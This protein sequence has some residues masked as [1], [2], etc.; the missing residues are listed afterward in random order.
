MSV[1]EVISYDSSRGGVSVITEKGEVTTSYLLIQHAELAD[2]GKAICRKNIHIATAHLDGCTPSSSSESA[3]GSRPRLPTTRHQSRPRCSQAER[4]RR[5]T[6]SQCRPRDAA[7]RSRPVRPPRPAPPR[8]PT[9]R[10][11]LTPAPTR[12]P[13]D[14]TRIRTARPAPP[15]PPRPAPPRAAPPRTTRPPPPRPATP[16]TPGRRSRESEKRM[17]VK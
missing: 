7:P 3:Q 17:S 6:A 10:Q 8:P 4:M 15:A 2:S 13:P 1:T 5:A 9:L 16:A 11:Q 12:R 14:R